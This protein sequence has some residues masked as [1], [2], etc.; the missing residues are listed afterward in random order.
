MHLFFDLDGTLTD[1]AEGIAACI[2]HALEELGKAAPPAE[3]LRWCIGP[4]LRQ[5]FVTLLGKGNAHLASAA[6]KKYR[7]RFRTVGLYENTIYPGI[8]VVLEELRNNGCSLAVA[9]AKPTVFARRIIEH[10]GLTDFFD[11]VDGSELDGTRADK[12]ELIRHILCRDHI[13]CSDAVMIGDREHD[14]IGA[15]K[16]GI[17]GIGVLWGYGSKAELVNAGAQFCVETPQ[18]LTDAVRALSIT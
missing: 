8:K 15:R 5:S 16:N 10:F 12:T 9:T 17:P 7:E 1:P 11:S 3:K 4:P 18:D 6:L 14:M 13:A 2:R